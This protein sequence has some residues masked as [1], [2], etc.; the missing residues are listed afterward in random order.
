[1]NY[2]Y[3]PPVHP[4]IN[5]ILSQGKRLFLL[6]HTVILQ[7]IRLMDEHERIVIYLG[8]GV[9]LDYLIFFYHYRVIRHESIPIWQLRHTIGRLRS[10]QDMVWVE[11]NRWLL[12]LVPGGYKTYPS[13]IQKINL[14]GELFRR[15]HRAI[16]DTFGRVTRKHGYTF[17]ITHNPDRVNQFY[18]NYYLP[19]IQSRFGRLCNLRKLGYF[20]QNLPSGFLLQVMDGEQWIA[21]AFCIKRKKELILTAFGIKAEETLG[22]AALKQGALSAVYYFA[23][24][25]AVQNQIERVNLL[26][27]RPHGQD[28]VFEHKRRWGADVFHDY[29][30]HTGILLFP[31]SA[32]PDNRLIEDTIIYNHH[33]F[34]PL[35]HITRSIR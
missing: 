24:Q 17:Q 6:H 27:S 35:W 7:Y 29:W 15:K 34:K 26:R 9:S 8:E 16:E 19:Y 10:E 4:I 25:W 22:H 3:N 14:D 18:S 1:M 11:L 12:F 32:T 30:P 13:I 5:W 33:H 28:G 21:G 31:S 20:I 2:H 23:I